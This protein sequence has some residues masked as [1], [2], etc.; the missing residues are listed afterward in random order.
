MHLSPEGVELLLEYS[1]MLLL[2]LDV[3][4]DLLLHLGLLEVFD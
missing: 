1:G 2:V 4:V 3:V